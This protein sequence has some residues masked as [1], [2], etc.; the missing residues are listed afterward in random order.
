MALFFGQKERKGKKD[1]TNW[2]AIIEENCRSVNPDTEKNGISCRCSQVMVCAQVF[3]NSRMKNIQYSPQQR[4]TWR[5]KIIEDWMGE[6]V[7]REI[8]VLFRRCFNGFF[9]SWKIFWFDSFICWKIDFYLKNN[10]IEAHFPCFPHQ[11]LL[12]SNSIN[13]SPRKF[14]L[15]A[16]VKVH[17]IRNQFSTDAIMSSFKCKSSQ[18]EHWANI[19]ITLRS[20]SMEH[21]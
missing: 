17:T 15:A 6:E 7:W 12:S 3:L 10:N 18:K 9:F 5:M 13:A 19:L 2:A 1:W 14:S 16:C 21:F 20:Y 4:N 11:F 8:A